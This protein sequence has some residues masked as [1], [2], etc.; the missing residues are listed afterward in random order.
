MDISNVGRTILALRK[1]KNVTQDELA[2]FVGVS[3]QAV[4]KWENG[5]APDCALLPGIADFFGVS[6]DALFGRSVTNYCGV[7]EAVAKQIADAPEKERLAL[8]DR[9]CWTMEVALFADYPSSRNDKTAAPPRVPG[10]QKYSEYHSESGGYTL[11]GLDSNLPF[12]LLLP[13]TP[14][15]SDFPVATDALC[16]FFTA[17]SDRDVLGA[18]MLITRTPSKNFTA[19]RLVKELNISEEKAEAVLGLLLKYDYVIKNEVEIDDVVHSVYSCQTTPL[20]ALSPFLM[21]SM[22]I[23]AG[24]N[25]FVYFRG[26]NF[27]P[28]MM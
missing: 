2:S 10:S 25:G 6:I 15:L 16:E 5:G 21:L 17:L 20:S 18:F 28:C 24:S 14:A 27:T 26:G 12:F 23:I 8:M 4:S 7:T 9:L 11:V 19:K 13:K 22:R 3:A 1:E